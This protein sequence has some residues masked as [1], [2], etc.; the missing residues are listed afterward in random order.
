[1][2]VW[3]GIAVDRLSSHGWRVSEIA[4]QLALE[5]T[6]APRGRGGFLLWNIGPVA[7][8]TQGVASVIR[9]R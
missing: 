7:K 3:P 6:I 8:D 1:M 5:K 2:P 9:T 4:T